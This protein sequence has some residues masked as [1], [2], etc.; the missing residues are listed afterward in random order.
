MANELDKWADAQPSMSV[1]LDFL[2]WCDD[3]KIELARPTDAGSRLFSLTEG[4][5]A[6]LARFF[7]IN[8]VKLE[9][10]RRA[11][12]HAASTRNAK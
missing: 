1:I 3:Q 8:T 5:E 4:R 12:L 2:E 6:M 7:K 9:N 11:L 10:E